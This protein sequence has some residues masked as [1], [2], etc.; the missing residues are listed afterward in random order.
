MFLDSTHIK[1]LRVPRGYR[2]LAV[3][4]RAPVWGP[5]F[6]TGTLGFAG[7]RRAEHIAHVPGRSVTS[8]SDRHEMV[9]AYE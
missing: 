7:A 5:T 2:N 3:T 1:G 6:P 8:V 9:G 4:P